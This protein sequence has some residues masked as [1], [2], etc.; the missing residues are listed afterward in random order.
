MR[1]EERDRLLEWLLAHG[2]PVVR[3]RTAAELC[4][5]CP[6][7]E[8]H[9][10]AQELLY[11]PSAQQWLERLMLGNHFGDLDCLDAGAL[12]RLGPLVHGS[13]PQQLENV[14]GRINELGLRAGMAPLDERMFPLM[15]FFWEKDGWREDDLYSAGWA[16]L[17][18]SIFAWGLLRAGYLP[19]P[20]MQSYL[21]ALVE[22]VQKIARDGVYDLYASDDEKKSLPK[23]WAEKPV[24]KR[25]VMASYHLPLIHD[26]YV[27]AYFPTW[28]MDGETAA[29]IDDVVRY[30]LHPRFQALY[31]GYGYAWSQARGAC[32]SWGWSPHLVG[33]HG[34]DWK[35]KS[36][37][38]ALVQQV[39]L[40]VRF[41]AAH[42][43][44]WFQAAVRHLEWFRTDSGTYC[45]PAHYLRD[46]PDGYYVNGAAM[47]LG[48][49]RRAVRR[50]ANWLEIESTFRML[51]IR[52]ALP[53]GY[54]PIYL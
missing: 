49:N 9:R 32:Y 5:D 17:I 11:S 23:T 13:K 52:L 1:E 42:C 7:V 6:P 22:N 29:R 40:M 51:K 12:A 50:A 36:E 43:S 41:P 27:L 28:M 39:E 30:V 48:E 54:E 10:M 45:F 46:L 14:L 31:P 37:P 34:F 19:D 44:R 16:G 26:L 24:L 2:G 20:L 38:A 21:Y 15:R 8:V 3:Y 25:E 4:P 53:D 35:N 33:Y 47:G 18:K